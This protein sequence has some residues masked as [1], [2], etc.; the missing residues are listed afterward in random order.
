MLSEA[1]EYDASFNEC[2]AMAKLLST[3]YF[4]EL[5]ENA[6]EQVD[7]SL[8]QKTARE[9]CEELLEFFEAHEKAL[10][11]AVMAN[12]LTRMPVIFKSPEEIK[13]YVEY[14]LRQC[15]NFSEKEISK[16]LVL[17]LMEEM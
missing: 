17:S 15:T 7:L 5:E 13:N 3:S 14:A 11:R 12:V 9:L 1:V 16:R 6:D 8:V 10:N 2:L 4:A